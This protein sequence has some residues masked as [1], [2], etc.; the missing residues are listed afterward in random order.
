MDTTKNESCSFKYS[1]L[2]VLISLAIFTILFLIATPYL[3]GSDQFWHF[4]YIQSITNGVFTTNE[5]YPVT[6]LD[7][8]WN[9]EMPSFFHNV[10]VLYIWSFFSIIFNN[11]FAGAI[12]VNYCSVLVTAFCIITIIL[13][14]AK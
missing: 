5:I 13:L 2:I 7:P 12:F 11:I 14:E 6:L 8:D 10:P 3:G 9:G 1:T 4:N